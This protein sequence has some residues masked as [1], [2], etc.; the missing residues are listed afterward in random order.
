MNNRSNVSIEQLIKR[1]E[2]LEIENNTL[3]K[4]LN[5]C[6]KDKQIPNDQTKQSQIGARDAKG[7]IL[8]IGQ[9]VRFIT[10]GKYKSTEGFIETIK[11]TRVISIDNRK[12]KIVRAH[13]NVE[14]ISE[15]DE[16]NG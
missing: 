9:K 5:K 8:K 7:R 6:I 11:E 12:N 14:V 10:K 16:R 4:D 13:Q 1:I 15:D 3:R 2:K